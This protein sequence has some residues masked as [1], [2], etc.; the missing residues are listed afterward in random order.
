MACNNGVEEQNDYPISQLEPDTEVVTSNYGTNTP[1]KGEEINNIPMAVM[2]FSIRLLQTEGEHVFFNSGGGMNRLMSPFSVLTAM[3][4]VGNGAEGETK[5]QMEEVLGISIENLNAFISEYR[6]NIPQ[7]EGNRFHMANSIWMTEDERFTVKEEFLNTNKEY[8]DADIFEKPFDQTTISDINQWV[9]EHTDGLIKEILNEIPRDAVM[10][11]VNALVFDAKWEETYEEGDIRE[12]KF[13]TSEGFEQKAELMFSS[14][15]MYLED[16]SA[17]GFIKYYEGRD[18]AFVGLLPNEDISLYEY[19]SG[20]SGESL[21]HLLLNA[22]EVKTNVWLPKFEVAYQTEL[23]DTLGAMGMSDVFDVRKADLSRLGT[24]THGNLYVDQVIHKSYIEVS[25]VGTKAGA[26]TAVEIK[27]ECALIEP[28]EVKE[29]R[30]D[31]PFLYM[32]IDCDMNQPIFIG[33]VNCI[34]AYRCGIIDDLC[35]YPP[36]EECGL[37]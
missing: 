24:S 3:S 27:D 9:K 14:E 2:D 35:G 17:T 12:A 19:I 8:Y 25:P 36:V 22:Q 33:T 16:E 18:Y 34:S 31:R 11:L 1:Q 29:V 37:E 28:E 15:H 23:K 10:Y 4:M 13:T 7:E 21:Y 26:A 32:I 6:K 20:L 30:L 5:A